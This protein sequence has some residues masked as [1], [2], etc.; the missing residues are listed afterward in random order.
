[1]GVDWDVSKIPVGKTTYLPLLVSC[2][3]TEGRHQLETL[4][5]SPFMSET[6][7]LEIRRVLRRKQSIPP[8]VYAP[9]PVQ[10]IIN[11]EALLACMNNDDIAELVLAELA[12]N[13]KPRVMR[14]GKI[15]KS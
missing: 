8:V 7:R 12:V 2:E 6:V 15:A 10:I 3:A 1:M 4:L 11:T 5:T 9:L 13:I 14:R